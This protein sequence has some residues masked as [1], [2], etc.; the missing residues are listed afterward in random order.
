[1]FGFGMR[2]TWLVLKDRKLIGRVERWLL[3]NIL[4]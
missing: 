3:V 2:T 1:M 4:L